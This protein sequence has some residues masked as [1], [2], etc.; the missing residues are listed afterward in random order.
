M[1]AKRHRL[2]ELKAMQSFKIFPL[3]LRVRV[4]SGGQASS[5]SAESPFL[6]F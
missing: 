4:R 6:R 2:L 5:I 1:A 3:R